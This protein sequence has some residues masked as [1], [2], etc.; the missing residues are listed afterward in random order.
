M[1]ETQL[2]TNVIFWFCIGLFWIVLWLY[3]YRKK[4][5]T[6]MLGAYGGFIISMYVF[7]Y[8]VKDYLSIVVK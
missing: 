2:C 1:T 8:A 3:A 7:Y 4:E 5:S 6:G